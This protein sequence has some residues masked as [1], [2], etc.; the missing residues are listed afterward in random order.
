MSTLDLIALRILASKAALAAGDVLR[1][2]DENLRSVAFSDARDVKLAADTTAEKIIRAILSESSNLPIFGEELGGNANL[3]NEGAL[4][5]VVDPLD[6][7][8]NYLRG[9]PLC[10]VSIGLMRGTEPLLGVIYDF[11]HDELY[12]GSDAEALCCNDQPMV[13]QWAST[14]DQAAL[15]TGFPTGMDKNA[16]TLGAYIQL[17]APYKKVRMVGTAALALTLVATGRADVYFEPSI[18]L[19][20]V[21]AGLALV[22]AAGGV[23]KMIPAN[24]KLPLACDV[25]AAGRPEFILS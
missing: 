19:W 20:D 9:L 23:L 10:A 3:V 22:K 25:W 2:P 5:W 13:P 17:L 18:R 24:S 8:F 7:T 15:C 1:K 11:N 14:I 21:A 16:D 6:G 12:Y 4:L